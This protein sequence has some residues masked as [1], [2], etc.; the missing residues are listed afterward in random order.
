MTQPTIRPAG[1]EEI[2]AIA[3]FLHDAWRRTYCG[4]VADSY[5]D[6]MSI[7]DRY[8]ALLQRFDA[9]TSR[10]LVMH[11]GDIL[12]GA[13]VFGTSFTK[14][15]EQ[16]G[17][18]TAIYLRED[19]IGKGHGHRLFV[20]IERELAQ[21]GYTHFV[22]DV[23]TENVRAC[24]FYQK[25]G[26][27]TVACHTIG[28]GGTDY[29]L[30]IMRKRNPL[31][32]RQET[33]AD[34]QGIYDLTKAAFAG[35]EHTDGD[36]Q[37]LPERLR[38]RPGYRPELSLVAEQGGQL[39]GHVLFTEIPIGVHRALLLGPVSVLPEFQGQGIGGALI[40][41]GH[42]V[43]ATLGFT[44][45]VLVG[46][47][48]YYPRFGYELIQGHG[49]TFPC[50]APAECMMVK[51]LSEAGRAVKGAAIFPPEHMPPT[52]REMRVTDIPQMEDFLYYA[53][54]QPPGTEPLPREVI[55][56]PDI[57]IYIDKFDPTATPGDC[58]VVAEIGGKPVGMAWVRIIPGFG[59]I[60]DSTPELAISVLP[61][62][63]GLGLGTKLMERLFVLLR[64]REYTRTS[65][66]VQTKNPACK[67]YRRLGYQV[68]KEKEEEFLMVKE[69]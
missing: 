59:H 1:R 60:D 30:T 49:I 46:H 38:N 61:E 6:S 69:L 43:A 9:G 36:E 2:Q 45:C 42:R 19:C 58:G 23:L 50:D 39:V 13:A 5:L 66:A 4:I 51:F 34:Y 3:A 31:T 55:F 37:E 15:Y 68:V 10:F 35:T 65:L 64:E 22:L 8:Q 14:D 67:F 32:I 52:V 17:E 16:D 26:Y 20:R 29:P 48:N 7:D 57:H 47:E 40:E 62:H 11:D 27:E 18:I 24:G 53:I 33:P 28:L 41:A 44:A 21:M 25:Q 12:I 54:F 63:R 56:Q